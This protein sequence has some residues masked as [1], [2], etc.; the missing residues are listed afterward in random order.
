MSRK[1][2]FILI[3]LVGATFFLLDVLI[4]PSVYF[5]YNPFPGVVR[6]FFLVVSMVPIVAVGIVVL[7]SIGYLLL[8]A[9]QYQ[10]KIGSEQVSINTRFLT[11][12]S[13]ET[14]DDLIDDEE[15][16]AYGRP[17]R[18]WADEFP[19]E[20]V[21]ESRYQDDL[22]EIC[23]GRDNEGNRERVV[24]SLIP[25]DDNKFDGQAVKVVIEGYKVGYLSRENA[26]KFRR[27]HKNRKSPFRCDAIILGGW[28]RGEG[29]IGHYGVRLKV[30]F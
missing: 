9:I 29:D 20:V 15:L 27:K 8:R 23:G 28:D 6:G 12:P 21:G 7:G 19:C 24:A 1:R 14:E 22:E 13:V 25:E 16:D 26:R 30:K 17:N 5:G 2:I 11:Q 3:A 18:T 4:Y 10:S